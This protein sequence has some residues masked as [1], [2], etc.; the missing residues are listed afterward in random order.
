MRERALAGLAV[1]FGAVGLAWLALDAES[2]VPLASARS[3]R[4][5]SS[6]ERSTDELRAAPALAHLDARLR[7]ASGE[8]ARGVRVTLRVEGRAATSGPWTAATDDDGGCAFEFPGD[9][10]LALE[11]G[12]DGGALLGLDP[13]PSSESLRLAPGERA[14]R[15][16]TLRSG[17]RLSGT[18]SDQDA[19]VL[20]ELELELRECPAARAQACWGDGLA[21]LSTSASSARTLS[22]RDGNFAFAGVP[23][24][25]WA[26]FVRGGEDLPRAAYLFRVGAEERARHLPLVL[27]RRLRVSGRVLDAQGGPCAGAE[28]E[29]IG[30]DASFQAHA[31]SASDGR[32]A[33][34]PLL[35]GRYRLEA[36]GTE[37]CVPATG[38]VRAGE[39]RVELRLALGGV[40]RVRVHDGSGAAVVARVELLGPSAQSELGSDLRLARLAPGRY[41]VV[42][43]AA[44]GRVG[45]LQDVEVESGLAPV[46]LDVVVQPGCA[47]R[48]LLRG[49]ERRLWRATWSRT[50]VAS[51]WLEPGGEASV[52]VPPGPVSVSWWSDLEE[53]GGVRAQEEQRVLTRTD[54]VAEFGHGAPR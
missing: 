51:G 36:R 8:P 47:L 26:L 31:H 12:R 10:S 2:G 20:G 22:A 3:E 46:P 38:V 16:W 33:L 17:C 14:V 27:P 28:L 34:G 18:V 29:L 42:A 54:E 24:G 41:A 44:D 4:T 5:A 52:S 23:P 11:F 43:R 35:D 7:E 53:N 39:T 30:L 48:L 49:D 6:A 50:T 1:V 25:G 45:V 40:L 13:Q 21:A 32:F 19:R 37:S 9:L 15:E